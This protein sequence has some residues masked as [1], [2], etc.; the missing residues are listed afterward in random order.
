VY[1][2]VEWPQM[3]SA[4][5]TS[6]HGEAAPPFFV[7]ACA[8]LLLMAACRLL[9]ALRAP[10]G[11]K[12]AASG[13]GDGGGEDAPWRAEFAAL[14]RRYLFGY[15]PAMLADWIMGAHIYALYRS[16]GF[17]VGGVA[18]LFLVGFGSSMTL[19]TSLAAATDRHGRR[20]GCLWY[21]V[22]YGASAL[23][24]NGTSWWLL[25]LSR[26]LGGAATSLLYSCFEGWLVDEHARL[27]LPASSLATLFSHATFWNACSA[28]A[29]GLLA[30]AA[31]AYGGLTAPFNLAVLP[32]VVSAVA[33]QRLWRENH[34]DTT[35]SVTGGLRAGAA[36]IFRAPHL[37]AVGTLSAMFESVMYVFIFL[38]TP[39]LQARAPHHH[40]RSDAG[41]QLHGGARG[42]DAGAEVADAA[43]PYGL[44]F[45]LFMLW[46]MAGSCAFE[47]LDGWGTKPNASIALVF[48]GSAGALLT[49]AYSRDFGLTLGAFLVY[50]LLIGVYWPVIATV[51]AAAIPDSMRVTMLTLF[52]VPLN[53][54]VMVNMGNVDAWGES[55][56]FCVCA[57][58]LLGAW[59]AFALTSFLK[60]PGVAGPGPGLKETRS[61]LAIHMP[62]LNSISALEAE[63]H[64]TAS[65]KVAPAFDYDPHQGD[66]LLD[67]HI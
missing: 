32:L 7:C 22:T 6:P 61:E 33:T 1:Y 67:S 28:V 4:M 56:V 46:K 30:E 43:L 41:L 51:R 52:R 19:G 23:C 25:A 24:N 17:S 53:L 58:A 27:K 35:Q 57:A 49:P 42:A 44:V 26:M 3:P 36:A 37:L 55:A 15:I 31:A 47:L 38:W 12:G 59:A 29:G 9:I 66:S 45:A 60:P 39:A 62:S 64:G 48:V 10:A 16:R 40:H 2:R 20:R 34:G 18:L 21:A 14:R 63:F 11:S 5:M 54:F 8:G 50:E 65:A 13:G